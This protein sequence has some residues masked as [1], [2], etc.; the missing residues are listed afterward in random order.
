MIDCPPSL[1]LLTLN[2]LVAADTVLVPIQC[3][4]FA[5]EGLADLIETL[6]RVQHQL[7]PKLE[8]EGI[9]L[10]MYDDRTN[11]SRQ[12]RDD[13]ARAF[14]RFTVENCHSPETSGSGRLLLRKPVL[15]YDI[16]SKGAEAYL[17]FAR[18]IIS[19]GN[20]KERHSVEDSTPCCPLFRQ[21]AARKDCWNSRWIRLFQTN[22]SRALFRS[23]AVERADSV[24][25]KQWHRSACDC[26]QSRLSI[27]I[28]CRRAPLASCKNCR[29]ED[30]SG[31]D[32]KDVSEYKTLELA[33]IENIQRQDLNPIEEATA[34]A[35]LINEFQLTQDEVAHRVGKDRS[36]IANYLRLLKLP[37]EIK[38]RIQNSELTMGHARALSS[39]DNA[40]AQIELAARIVAEQLNVRQIEELIRNYKNNGK[41]QSRKSSEA[42]S[43][44]PNVR[45]AETSL[46]ELFG[47][48]VTI[49]QAE[50]GKGTLE[51]HFENGDDLIRIYDLI[52][53]G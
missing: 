32:S 26:P 8:L 21:P 14:R 43:K 27:P 2:A 38:E 40:A 34:Y 24:D 20:A 23:P 44:D 42:A 19:H 49:H 35:S 36:S 5:L 22:T 6:R 10:T 46:Q 47:T 25:Q 18:E 30:D 31:S 51:I 7:N 1:G 3:E 37:Q 13:I 4:Y 15:L 17:H 33:L 41:K 52:V 48:K 53:G 45:A 11:L 29:S 9:V 39:L 12:V 16:K 50:S 28:N